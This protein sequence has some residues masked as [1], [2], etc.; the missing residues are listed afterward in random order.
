[1][2][3][4]LNILVIMLLPFYVFSQ[5]KYPFN[6]PDLPI[7]T[8]VEDLLGRLTI[9]EKVSLL[10]STAEEIKRLE[11]DK[12]YHGNEGLHGVVKGGR[13]TVFPQAV[14]LAS[15]WNPN[16]I[17]NVATAISDEARAKW[18][19]YN[20]G[21]D[22]LNPY[23][24][25]LTM[26]SPTI[27]MARDPRWGRTP[28][29]YGEDPYL[30]GR[31]GLSF[32]KG[33]QGDDDKYLKV[34]STPKHFVA[35]NQE[36][37]RFAYNAEI[38]ERA[39]REYYLPA[40]KT[41]IVEGKAQ[42]IMSAYNAINGIPATANSM[43]LND[44]LRKEWGFKGYV[45]SDCGAPT[46]LKKSH[47]YVSND[48]L[49]AKV[50]IEAGLDLE[51]GDNIYKK[52]LIPALEQGLITEEL[53]NQSVR[54]ILESRFKLGI[55][56]PKENNPYTRISPDVIGSQKHQNLA[57]ET[58][59][60]SIVLLKNQNKILPL[61]ATKIK[62]IAVVGFN[63]N[64]VVFGDYSG[65][66]VIAPVSPLKGIQNKVG[67][68]IDVKYVKWKTAA[69]NLNLLESEY[70]RNDKNDEK[71]LFAEY[72]DDK[73]LEGTP[74]TRTDKVVNFD[75]VNQPPDSY[76]NYR[77]K[78]MRW[79]GYITPNITGSYKI[80]VNSDDGVR[81]WLNDKL[82]V[83]EWH[84]RGKTTDQVD[85]KMEAGKKYSIKLEYFD[86]G[87]DAICQLLW[88]VPG[89]SGDIYEEDWKAA[90]TSDYVIAVMGINKTIEKEGKDRTEL[91]L[92][93]D[94]V[95]YLKKMYS[96]NKNVVVVLVAGS[97]LSVNW[98]D[99]NVP[100]IVEAW[101][102]GESGGTAIADVLFG[103]YNPGGRLPFTFYKSEKDLPPMDDYEVTN[104]RTYMYFEGE[105]L[106]PFGYGLS[107]TSFEY[108]NMSIDRKDDTITVS[109]TVK[110]TGK[111]KGDEVVQLYV[112]DVKSSVKRPI[113]QLVGFDR[114]S[115]KVGEAKTISFEVSKDKLMFWDEES[116]QWVFEAGKFEFMLGAS[117]SDI[118]L[119][120]TFK[121][122]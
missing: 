43:L 58:S 42:S 100:A 82:V 24:D 59:R 37:N 1:M 5:A 17:H 118:R 8:R 113:K 64:Q 36:E 112:N 6:N 90:R 60:Q 119:N 49:A 108:N 74:R 18:N 53:I 102:P 14:A 109:M 69:R 45:V 21:K 120:K 34:V 15:T 3:K 101:Y 83:D 38:S 121:I 48:T 107:Y 33:L 16:L 111:Y 78:S 99:K 84:N 35:N 76:S 103:D 50:A 27:N 62:K 87:G 30:T 71:G 98:M 57:L 12:Y 10:V 68:N 77:H 46:Y 61:D 32:V 95:N 56:D 63:A 28:E 97:S 88:K 93:E 116:D 79:T 41:A 75:P 65:L 39:L 11:V 86:N 72:Y 40:F 47:H 25:L 19:F 66:S 105:A 9:T 2:R 54:R 51:C 92:P 67:K 23:S 7:D 96:I 106:Y 26:W 94:Q 70:L 104:G 117:S 29:T 85:I 114:V 110:N 20:Q 55:F 44:I 22:Q 73:F 31:I 91:G 81:L 122:K 13:F 52:Y 89:G 115:L 4:I 80:G